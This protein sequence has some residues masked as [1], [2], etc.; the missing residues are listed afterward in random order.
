MTTTFTTATTAAAK[1]NTASAVNVV[2]VV[3]ASTRHGSQPTVMAAS[4]TPRQTVSTQ[5]YMKVAMQGNFSPHPQLVP[6]RQVCQ[7]TD[8]PHPS[9]YPLI[10]TH[11]QEPAWDRRLIGQSWQRICLA[12]TRR[13]PHWRPH[14]RNFLESILADVKG[15]QENETSNK[16]H[17]MA[18]TDVSVEKH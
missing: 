15:Q 6:W 3:T 2:V 17:E 18:F 14:C 7:Q 16:V 13:R 9:R 5:T 10:Y 11:L 12:L 4:R 8:E 1:H